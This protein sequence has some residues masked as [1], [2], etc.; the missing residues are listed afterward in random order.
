MYRPGTGMVARPLRRIASGGEVSRVMLACKVVLG[1]ADGVDTLVFDEVD[2]GVGGS[3]A[4]SLALVLRDLARTH[5]VIV[6]THLAQVAVQ[7][8]RHYL[9]QK[10]ASGSGAPETTLAEI[11]GEGRVAEIARMLSG[12][13]SDI[14]LEHARRL[15]A[16]AQA[17]CA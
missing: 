2:A 8:E 15:L 3:V 16:E 7:G 10:H 13:T 17:A 6:V 9:V 14:S 11:S 5:Q 12:D 1:E 4:R